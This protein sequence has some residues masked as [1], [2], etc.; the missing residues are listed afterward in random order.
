[1][2]E[3]VSL[4]QAGRELKDLVEHLRPGESVRLCDANGEAVALLVSVRSETSEGTACSSW[5][6]RW[7]ELAERI[8]RN[9]KSE[10]SAVEIVSEM[11]R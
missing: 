3:N 10:K 4:K 2:G 1:M 5:W 6:A 11:R 9:W 8:G 7:D